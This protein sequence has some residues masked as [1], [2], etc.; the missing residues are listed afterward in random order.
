MALEPM[1]GT[2]IGDDRYDDRLP[3][4]SDEG[5][6][7]RKAF[8]EK[9]LA[10]RSKIDAGRLDVELRTTLDVLESGCRREL[11]SIRWRMD[12]FAAVTHLFGPGNL[13][14]DIGSLQR[15]DSPERVDKLVARLSA[16]PMYL[17]AIGKVAD[18]AAR[19]GQVAPGLV[20][21]RAIGQIER[22]LA[23]QPE[24]S[25]GMS[26]VK[27]AGEED[28]AR[29][30]KVLREEVWPAYGNYLETLKRYRPFARDTIGLLALPDGDAMYASCILSF[31][32]L[33][34]EAKRVHDTGLEQLASIQEERQHIAER[35]GFPDASAAIKEHTASG[36]NTASSREDM[37]R[38]I[39]DQ[40]RRSWEAAPGYFGR[41]PKENCRVRKVEEFRED[42]MPGAFY[43]PGTA[44]GS[45]PGV[46]YVNTGHLSE[47]YLH[48][49]ATTTFHEGNPGHHFQITIEM[50]FTD[51]M[52]LRRF[53][54]F[55]VGDAFVEGWG[56]YSERLS[57]EMGLFQDD[58]ERLGMLE[59]Q[60]FRA[61]R[62]IVDTGIHALGWDR[63]RAI[64]QMMESGTP[65][66]DA[67]IEVDRYI[68][69][70][71]QALAYMIGQLEI[72]RWRADAAKRAGSSFALKGFHDRLLALGSL[73][74]GVLER[75]LRS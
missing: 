61:C 60:G 30:A 45:R 29:V 51:R 66:A 12:R 23:L 21:D 48:Q 18:E 68:S 31:T 53:G 25:P 64:K 47:R 7:A 42:D 6:A 71:G 63:E 57:E 34:L 43:Q 39:E 54:G 16:I 22:L 44:D 75:E 50:E 26:P 40:V 10:E 11:D 35:L 32:T 72:Q 74:L 33:P 65:R 24:A 17:G 55:L 46:Y 49:T 56:L 37:L 28:R 8:M 67:E 4:P 20:V 73:P 58:Y 9:S 13:L 41:L 69:W 1:I 3:D 15:G 2:Y 27:A 36:K 70:P 52:P 62:L 5:V 19:V 59:A 14:A 38:L